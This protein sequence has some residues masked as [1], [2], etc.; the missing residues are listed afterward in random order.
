MLQCLSR[1]CK[2]RRLSQAVE[3]SQRQFLVESSQSE[4]FSNSVSIFAITVSIIIVYRDGTNIAMKRNEKNNR[5]FFPTASETRRGPLLEL[6]V[7]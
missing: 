3:H 6:L 1:T 4:F 2:H 7:S 5:I